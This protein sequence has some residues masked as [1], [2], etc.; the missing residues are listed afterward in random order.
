MSESNGLAAEGSSSARLRKSNAAVLQEPRGELLD[1]KWL[2]ELATKCGADDV[3]FAAVDSTHLIS[4]RTA[5]ADSMADA[6]SAIAV[7]VRLN[8]DNARSKW[9]SVVNQE[10]G[11]ANKLVDEVTGKLSRELVNNGIRAVHI[12]A[13]FPMDVQKWPE[14]MWA[15]SHKLVAEAAGLGKM[16]HSRNFLHHEFGSFLCLG[17]VLIDRDVSEYGQPLEES[18]CNGCKMCVRACPTGCVGEDGEFTSISCIVHNY[19]YRLGGF[20]DWVDNVAD[21]KNAADYRNRVTERESLSVWQALT[22]STEYTCCNCIA[23][24]SVGI[25]KPM[26]SRK[27]LINDLLQRYGSVYVLAGS[28]AET[29]A[30]QLYPPSS[31][32]IVN[33]G[34]RASDTKSFLKA[35]PLIFQPGRSDGLE[36]VYHFTFTGESPCEG[37]VEIKHRK[38]SISDG[39]VGSADLHVTADSRTWLNMLSGEANP[40]WAVLTGKLKLKGP[41]KL[42]D[43]FSQCFPA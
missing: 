39:H 35:L 2:E 6:R 3:G 32:K 11:Y 27:E 28:D 15:I 33:G 29:R 43:A 7:V 4:D 9:N 10:F 23:A 20:L 26:K 42:L 36:A 14:R 24:C 12:P 34:A 22:Y 40:L 21:S 41:K 16:G 8:P 17:T 31:V 30:R 1:S 38:V 25:G 5:I 13:G 19:R 18:P 37:T